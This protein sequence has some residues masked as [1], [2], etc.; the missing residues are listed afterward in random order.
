MLI[1]I[2]VCHIRYLLSHTHKHIHTCTHTHVHTHACTRMYIHMHTHVHIHACTH[3][4][5]HSDLQLN[6]QMVFPLSFSPVICEGLA[7]TFS[8]LFS[9]LFCICNARIPNF[10]IL[11]FASVWT[12]CKY[13]ELRLTQIQLH[14]NYC[15]KMYLIT[16]TMYLTE[17]CHIP[18]ASPWPVL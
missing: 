15:K 13:I 18:L 8:R 7:H 12:H 11:N 16:I 2:C 14:W 17:L 4:C 1:T 6:I 9:F 3:T 5:T 10:A